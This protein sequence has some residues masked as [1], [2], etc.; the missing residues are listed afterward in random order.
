MRLY[1]SNFI[2]ARV[3]KSDKL[4]SDLGHELCLHPS[5]SHEFRRAELWCKWW[6][7]SDSPRALCTTYPVCL[8]EW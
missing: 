5:A 2:Q 1:T 3:A 4:N 7:V 8:A 6:I